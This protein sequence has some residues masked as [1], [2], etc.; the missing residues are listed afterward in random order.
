MQ[1]SII[2]VA[3]SDEQGLGPCYRVLQQSPQGV[4]LYVLPRSAVAADMEMY[5]VD[6]P[7]RVLDWRLHGYRGPSAP[8]FVPEPSLTFAVQAQQAQAVAEYKRSRLVDGLDASHAR[9]LADDVDQVDAEADRLKA[10]ARKIRDAEVAEVKGEVT[11]VDDAGFAALR[12]L[13]LADVDDIAIERAR[14][15]EQLASAITN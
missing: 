8:T 3:V 9:T 15:R 13:V 12:A 4:E 6:D 1:I 14:Y 10:K 7:L 11:I 2:G 5:G